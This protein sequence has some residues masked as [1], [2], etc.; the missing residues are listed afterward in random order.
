MVSVSEITFGPL[1]CA[2]QSAGD[3]H[4]MSSPSDNLHTASLNPPPLNTDPGSAYHPSQRR[5]QGIPGIEVV[6]ARTGG[7]SGNGGSGSRGKDGGS[8]PGW[9]YATWYSG[10]DIE[11]PENYVLLVRSADQ[12]LTWSEPLLVIDPA[13]TVRAF[14]PVLWLDPLGR[15]WFFWSQN[16]CN[17]LPRWRTWNGRGGVWFTRCDDPSATRLAWTAPQRIA[18]GV[19]MNKPVVLADGAWLLPI[20]G[21]GNID[22]KL[23]ELQTEAGAN[24][25]VSTDEGRTFTLRGGADVPFST[26]DEH[27]VIERRDRSLWL[28]ARTSYGIGQSTST[29]AGATWSPGFPAAIAGPGSRFHLRRLPAAPGAAA[30]SGRLLLVNHRNFTGRSHLTAS[31]SDDDGIT[32]FAHLLLDERAEVSYP[33]ATFTADG[34]ILVI[35]DRERHAAKEILMVALTEADILAGSLVSP[36]SF[37]RHLVNRAG[38]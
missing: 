21:W 30:S 32:W 34:R 18:N 29:D 22:P 24:V 3:F 12:G 10:G 15:L 23:P 11:G 6:N 31:L 35:Y 14:D 1:G 36:G 5:W 2:P 4:P 37:T 33:D 16:F 8:G 19:M 26:F 25:Y 17:A 9:L 7:V 27:M 28:L 20:S 38:S 13:G